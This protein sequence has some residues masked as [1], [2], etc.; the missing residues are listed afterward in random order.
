MPRPPITDDQL[1]AGL[2]RW[3]RGLYQSEAAAE[4]L[5]R[6]RSLARVCWDA[7][8]CGIPDGDV[9]V[10]TERPFVWFDAEVVPDRIDTLGLSG[11]QYRLLQVAASLA[12][13]GMRIHLG[14]CLSSLDRENAALVLAAV[15]HA[16]GTHQ[17][18]HPLTREQ[19]GPLVP[20]TAV[21]IEHMR[22]TATVDAFVATAERQRAA[23]GR[24]VVQHDPTPEQAEQ[25]ARATAI[26]DASDV[27]RAER[28]AAGAVVQH[29]PT[30]GRPLPAPAEEDP[31]GSR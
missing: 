14:E 22:M 13:G 23:A 31:E 8:F 16:M 27:H 21:D 10:N 5:V 17:D 20:W 29:D 30:V 28:A 12:P 2:R 24:P 7:G 9:E 25:I 4:L 18:G 1:A 26:A 3:G 15:S 6:H 11:S 19:Y